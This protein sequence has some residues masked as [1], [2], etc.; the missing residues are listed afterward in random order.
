MR[1]THVIWP[2]ALI[3]C[4]LSGCASTGGASSETSKERPRPLKTPDEEVP[5]VVRAIE[6]QVDTPSAL[7]A[8]EVEIYC[9]KNY[10]WDVSL[11]GND[12][13]PQKA[14]GSE[15]VSIA[16]GNARATFRQLEIRAHG[17]IVFRRSGLDVV[18][19]I[20]IVARGGAAHA[21]LTDGSSPQVRRA[22]TIRIENADIH[23]SDNGS[24]DRVLG[25]DD[26]PARVL[27][28]N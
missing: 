25:L 20:K 10:E 4:L 17:R 16:E 28:G 12:V 7:L 24:G 5:A 15:Q 23:F 21:F 9:S 27:R 18:P 14:Q 8:E 13:S 19:F 1:F 6:I 22:E 3:S 2:L 11:T 26:S